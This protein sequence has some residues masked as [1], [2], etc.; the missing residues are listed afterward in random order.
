MTD[1]QEMQ[2]NNKA[3][4]YQISL[5]RGAMQNCIKRYGENCTSIELLGGN[6]IG[7]IFLS[8]SLRNEFKKFDS[9]YQQE[10]KSQATPNFLEYL[11]TM[12]LLVVMIFLM[13]FMSTRIR[14]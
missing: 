9:N 6:Y 4:Q 2:K 3:S 5:A 12:V 10:T 7:R 13:F 1:M 8:D 14:L 11:V